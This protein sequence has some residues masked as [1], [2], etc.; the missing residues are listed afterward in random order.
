[1]EFKLRIKVSNSTGSLVNVKGESVGLD[2]VDRV[3][4]ETGVTELPIEKIHQ[5]YAGWCR[6]SVDIIVPE[7]IARKSKL[8]QERSIISI[9]AAKGS[10]DRFLVL[11][12]YVERRQT[13]GEILNVEPTMELD[14]ELLTDSWMQDGFPVENWNPSEVENSVDESEIPI[15][16]IGDIGNR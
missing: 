3:R 13:N 14:Q 7:E 8:F 6:S 11:E 16:P 2:F 10:L 1:M 9:S 5:Y 12:Y 15:Y 4:K